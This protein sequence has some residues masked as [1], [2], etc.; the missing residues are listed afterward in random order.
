MFYYSCG[1]PLVE[2]VVFNFH[3]SKCNKGIEYTS[4]NISS[5]KFAG[6]NTS[7]ETANE[8]E[9]SFEC[10]NCNQSYSI[11]IGTNMCETYVTSYDLPEDTKAHIEDEHEDYLEAV[12]SNTEF[13][14]TFCN[15]MEKIK[16][17]SENNI[18][19]AE[20]IDTLDKLLFSNMITCLET[21]LSDA[22]INTIFTN[23]IFMKNF[24]EKFENYKKCSFKF[25]TIYKQM[26]NIEKKIKEDLLK[27]LYHNLRVIK[28]IYKI[29]FDID[30]PDITNLMKK[31]NI[32][33]DLV[34]RNGK[35]KNGKEHT[36]SKEELNGT[37]DLVFEFVKNIDE[38]LK[39]AKE[40]HFRAT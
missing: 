29:T 17:L 20:L 27:L 7:S 5:P 13:F 14:E 19:N 38:Q 40:N 22:L 31:V 15:Q 34:H 16:K 2:S 8:E 23:E 24:V 18:L 3:C 26:D 33:H 10:P 32:R 35:N 30:F 28:A 11:T 1:K 6:G 37:Y 36:I 9:Y 39:A 25:N 12:E 4:H 21:Y